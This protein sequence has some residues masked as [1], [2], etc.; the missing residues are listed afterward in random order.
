[1]ATIILSSDSIVGWEILSRPDAPW[2]DGAYAHTVFKNTLGA[3]LADVDAEE[4]TAERIQYIWRPDGDQSVADV[5]AGA[6]FESYVELDEGPFKV[7]HGVVQ[8]SEAR[9]EVFA[10]APTPGPRSFADDFQR[11][12]LGFTWEP[13]L[14]QYQIYTTPGLPNA[15]GCVP[16]GFFPFAGANPAAVRYF[17]PLHSDNVAVGFTI[18]LYPPVEYRAGYR[19]QYDGVCAAGRADLCAG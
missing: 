2:P 7:R 15:V 11:T 5:P 4:V 17:R 1:V 3:Q 14:G 9:F 19:P 10:P 12:A 6:R 8:R 16:G 13:M 18:A